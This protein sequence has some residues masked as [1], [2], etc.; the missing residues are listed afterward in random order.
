[1]E[2]KQVILKED[3]YGYK[4]MKAFQESMST[5]LDSK[6]SYILEVKSDWIS[7]LDA[8]ENEIKQYPYTDIEC[9]N[10]SMCSRYAGGTGRFGGIR[11]TINIDFDI[12]EKDQTYSF[13]I[14]QPISFRKMI[15]AICE[16]NID[17]VDMVGVIDIYN[18][19]PDYEQRTKYFETHFN[20]LSKKYK[21]E[22]P[23]FKSRFKN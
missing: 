1:M 6:I 23:R 10:L 22:H 12:I 19:Y 15:D 14:V 8:E 20:E 18:K 11:T 3:S 13:E 4:P 7:L 9:I 21:L 5:Y 17:V 2:R 16:H